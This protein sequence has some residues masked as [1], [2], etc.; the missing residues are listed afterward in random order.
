MIEILLVDDHPSV[1][2]GTK[3]LLEQE[4]DMRVTLACTPEQAIQLVTSQHFDVMLIDMHMPG[5]NGIDLA[6]RILELMPDAIMLIYTGFEV[7]YHFNLIMDAG[8]SGFVLKT[9]GK[10]QL[11]TAVRCALRGEVVLPLG[12][13]KQLRRTTGTVLERAPGS[14]AQSITNKEYDILKEIARGKSNKEIAGTIM[15]SQR[16]LE[17]CLT[18]LF[19]KLS[20]KSRIEAAMKAK[21]LGILS[22]VDFVQM[23]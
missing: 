23:Q 18:S 6:K 5:M 15:M 20:V 1:M 13:V 8:L 17:Y 4:Q 11:V 19:Q 21:Q 14:Q 10:E 9:A 2:E 3:M 22:D 7:G 16:S 12:L